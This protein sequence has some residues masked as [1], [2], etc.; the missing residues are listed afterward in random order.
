MA[1][2][3]GRMNVNSAHSRGRISTQLANWLVPI[4]REGFQCRH[5][6]VSHLI[7][8]AVHLQS[9]QQGKTNGLCVQL[10]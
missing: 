10:L 5:S 4:T 6:S 7:S 8:L 9:P 2:R 3:H 1:A